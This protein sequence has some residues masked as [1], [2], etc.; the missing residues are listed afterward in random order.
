MNGFGVYFFKRAGL[1]LLTLVL[2]LL[3]TYLLLRLA[4]GDPTR[5]SMIGSGGGG[6][7][8]GLSAD[9][10]ELAVNELI[11]EKLHYDKPPVIGFV[12]WAKDI[13]LHG[14][15][16]TSVSVDKGRPVTSL[17][18]ERLPVTLRLNVIAILLTYLLAIPLGLLAGVFPDRTF[19]RISTFVLF[20][21][22]SLPVLWV[23][24]MLQSL[25]C[26]GGVY[27][28][29]PLKGLEPDTT[30]G[31]TT[32]Q[33]F[34]K[35][36]MHYVMPILCMT[37][38]SFAGLSRFVRSSMLDTMQQEYIR[39]ARAK[40]VAETDVILHHAFRNTLVLMATLFAGILPGLVSGS[41]LTEYVFSIPG[42][43]SLSMTALS[44]R[45]VPL[46]M[47][48]F[49][50]SSF[51]TLAGMMLSDILYVIADPRINFRSR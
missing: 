17:I 8:A 28:V 42:M 32:W 15:F 18:L 46:V 12:L 38:A 11:R 9:K 6:S 37:Y 20:F 21:L 16:G 24:L 22:Y 13:V 3:V 2:I 27:P 33:I 35:T 23:A 31:L 47:A 30:S 25:F 40:G 26:S 34:G 19:D 4:P 5:S 43:G 49:A 1:A 10:P 39:T 50:F 45:D 36:C 29:F 44:S 41:I 7:G 48:L 51:L 14:D